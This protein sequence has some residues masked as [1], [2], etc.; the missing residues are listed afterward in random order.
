MLFVAVVVVVGA[1]AEAAA[2]RIWNVMF[3]AFHREQKVLFSPGKSSGQRP[4]K[5]QVKQHG[6]TLSCARAAP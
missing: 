1:A 5:T 4:G 2:T 3:S 6:D